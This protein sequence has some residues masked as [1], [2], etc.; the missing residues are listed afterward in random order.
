MT[1]E[2][3]WERLF[4]EL[5]STGENKNNISKLSDYTKGYLMLKFHLSLIL[6]L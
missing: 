1:A 3:A 5:F 2:F 6:L 4:E